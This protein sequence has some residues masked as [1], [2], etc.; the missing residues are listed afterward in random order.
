MDKFAD[1]I[2]AVMPKNISELDIVKSKIIREA[3]IGETHCIF[4]K[5]LSEETKEWLIKEGFNILQ[6]SNVVGEYRL[7][8]ELVGW[9][10]HIQW[11]IIKRI[12]PIGV[13]NG[14]KIIMHGFDTKTSFRH[15]KKD[16]RK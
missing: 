14:D 11:R 9:T 4:Y 1:N 7:P 8:F 2:R 13:T 16:K 10:L 15:P 6:L 3:Q 5:K 12:N